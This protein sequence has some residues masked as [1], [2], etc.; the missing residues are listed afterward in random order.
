MVDRIGGKTD[1]TS[2]DQV[3]KRRP[4][5]ADRLMRSTEVMIV[6]RKTVDDIKARLRNARKFTFD[7]RAIVHAGNVIRDVPELLFRESQFARAPFP[8]TWIEIP[9][10]PLLWET[11]TG[12][13][14]DDDCDLA[15]GFLID[16]DTVY[17][18]MAGTKDRPNDHARVL[19]VSYLLHTPFAEPARQHFAK[20]IGMMT[21]LEI[22][23]YFWGQTFN[24]ATIADVLDPNHPIA[25]LRNAHSCRLLPILDKLDSKQLY[26][27]IAGG[28]GEFRDLIAILLLLNRPSLTTYVEDVPHWR[29]FFGGKLQTYFAHTV[30]TINL[31]PQPTL[32]MLGTREGESIARRR[33]EVRGTWCSNYD[34]REFAKIGCVHDYR[35]DPDYVG[36]DDPDDPDHWQCAVC[37]GKRYWRSMTT[38]GDATR[39]FVTKDYSVQ[40]KTDDARKRR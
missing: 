12:Q 36:I 14:A 39:G 8:L 7:D 25:V 20:S 6:Q 16:H 3:M 19:P 13:M 21:P 38:R 2:Q 29:G 35:L 18:A 30:I 31:D 37:G 27:I 24:G 15:L 32:R 5:L 22:D 23:G 4:L 11:I 34:A 26:P 28:A 10:F 33:H 40:A 1:V 9:N 17:A